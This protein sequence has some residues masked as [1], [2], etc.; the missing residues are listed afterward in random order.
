[1]RVTKVDLY[2]VEIPPIPAIAR[3]T[4]RIYDITLCAVHTDEG[5][6]RKSVV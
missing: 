4:A 5:I 6:D 2:H 3:H 1:M